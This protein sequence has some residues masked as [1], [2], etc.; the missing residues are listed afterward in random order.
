M[1]LIIAVLALVS[2]A[3]LLFRASRRHDTELSE[4]QY[5]SFEPPHNA[6]PLFAPTDAE[7]RL[8]CDAE[9][10]RVIAKREY[11]ARAASQSAVDAVLHAWRDAPSG[12]ST[13][14]LLRVTA[15]SGSDG[16]FARAAG[17]VITKFRRSGINGLSDNDL[18]ALIDSHIRLLSAQES[19]SGA[20]F[21][22]KQEAAK[23]RS[24]TGPDQ[25]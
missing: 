8:E 1:L 3:F 4:P 22:L 14:E 17:E 11:R 20:I 23:L 19:A 15:E 13:G 24:G 21:W 7:L 9:A 10:A 2:A 6:R 25:R 16:D 5:S 12:E 18:A